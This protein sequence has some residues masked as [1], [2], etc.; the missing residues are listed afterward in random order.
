MER[1][2]YSDDLLDEKFVSIDRRLGDL[3]GMPANF[4]RM[5]VAL[6]SL[7][8][9]VGQLRNDAH[10]DINILR[11]DTRQVSRVLLGFLTALLVA[12]MAAIIGVVIIL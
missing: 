6:E 4:E 2:K 12:M 5:S 10:E 1:V 9:E 7:A 11:D 8:R 3:R